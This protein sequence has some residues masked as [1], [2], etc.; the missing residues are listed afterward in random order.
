MGRQ[1]PD[2]LGELPIKPEI[3]KAHKALPRTAVLIE[4]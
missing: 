2:Y 3:E 4:S 1:S